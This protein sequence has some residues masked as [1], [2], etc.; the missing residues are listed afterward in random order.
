MHRETPMP[1]P[2]KT[3]PAPPESEGETVQDG[4]YQVLIDHE[5]DREGGMTKIPQPKRKKRIVF[6]Q[7]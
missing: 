2:D 4:V 3:P 1:D 6:K 5:L 7:W